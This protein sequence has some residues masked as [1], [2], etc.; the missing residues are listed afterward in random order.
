[1]NTNKQMLTV[2]ELAVYFCVSESTIRKMVRESRIPFIR[3]F[4]KI[5]F[6]KSVIDNWINSNQVNSIE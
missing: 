2:K 6:N 4:S 1:M 3:I 5:L